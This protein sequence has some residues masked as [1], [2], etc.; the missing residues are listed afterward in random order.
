MKNGREE[1]DFA[2]AITRTLGV[3][4]EMMTREQCRE[5]SKRLRALEGDAES[6]AFLVGMALTLDELAPRAAR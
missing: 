1:L 6:R 5:A 2:I 4:A 3:F